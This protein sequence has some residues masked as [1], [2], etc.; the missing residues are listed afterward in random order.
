[1]NLRDIK[2]D[3][4]YFVGEFVDDCTLFLSLNPQKAG[5]EV[6]GIIEEAIDLYNDL[7]DKANAKVEGKKSAYFNL[8]RKEMLEKVDALYEKLSGIVSAKPSDA[9]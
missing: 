4:E 3:I 5:D 2:K 6:T 1:M 7:K 9:E 8:L